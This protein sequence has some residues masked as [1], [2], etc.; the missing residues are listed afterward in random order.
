[1]HTSRCLARLQVSTTPE[2]TAQMSFGQP[3]GQHIPIITTV[4]SNS[5][6]KSKHVILNSDLIFIFGYA[7]VIKDF[8]C[9]LHEGDAF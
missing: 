8:K 9:F 2:V 4:S 7:C 6:R 3:N 5:R 1:M